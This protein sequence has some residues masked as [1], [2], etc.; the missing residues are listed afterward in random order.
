M[1]IRPAI[2]S[3][4]ERSSHLTTCLSTFNHLSEREAAWDIVFHLVSSK[5]LH[6]YIKPSL[7]T[8]KLHKRLTHNL[9]WVRHGRL[10][11][12]VYADKRATAVG[13]YQQ[14]KLGC[15]QTLEAP[16]LR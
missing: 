9:L 8:R 11:Y 4:G 7:G 10:I 14:T 16:R 5:C 6:K 2:N 3:H 13:E 15:A 12:F 1:V